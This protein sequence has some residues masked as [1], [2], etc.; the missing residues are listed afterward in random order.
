[1]LHLDLCAPMLI[2][3]ISTSY[4][5]DIRDVD[6]RHAIPIKLRVHPRR[7]LIERPRQSVVTFIR[8]RCHAEDHERVGMKKETSLV[9]SRQTPQ[10]LYIVEDKFRK[11]DLWS[12]SGLLTMRSGSFIAKLSMATSVAPVLSATVANDR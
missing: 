5:K 8:P 11:L 3:Q 6:Q 2:V 7:L 1:M 9:A 4:P 12:Q 10:W